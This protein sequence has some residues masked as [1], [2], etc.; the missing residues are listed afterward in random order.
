MESS[1]VQES[2][3]LQTSA[4]PVSDDADAPILALPAPE[5]VQRNIELNVMTGEPVMMDALGPV[6]VNSDGTLSR[7]ANW[8]DMTEQERRLTQRRI[9]KRNVERLREFRD[10]GELKG[11]LMSALSDAPPPPSSEG[12]TSA[13]GAQNAHSS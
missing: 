13:E 6:V 2:T 11:E 9:A 8:H 3:G 1:G 4:L 12:I 5:D 7:I 10:K